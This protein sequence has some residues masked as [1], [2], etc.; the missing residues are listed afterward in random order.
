MQLDER[1]QSKKY[2]KDH[3]KLC[4]HPLTKYLFSHHFPDTIPGTGDTAVNMTDKVPG[5][6][7][8]SEGADLQDE[9]INRKTTRYVNMETR[10]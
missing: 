10:R 5:P 3:Y 1:S 9:T 7:E 4:I 2:V 6:T 8:L